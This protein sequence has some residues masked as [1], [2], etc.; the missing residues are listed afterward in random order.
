[1]AKALV[2]WGGWEGHEPEKVGPLFADWLREAGME[3]TLTDSLSC[4]DDGEAVKSYDL[5]VPVWTM[6]KIGKE[7]ALNVCAAVAAGP[8]SRAVTAA[9][10]TPSA[11]TWTGSS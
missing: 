3:V 5:I 10:A 4:F 1:M 6:S 7:Q 9:C 11:R 8:G 2:T